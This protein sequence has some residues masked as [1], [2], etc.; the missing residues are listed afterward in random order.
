MSAELKYH[1]FVVLKF[2]CDDPVM[3]SCRDVVLNEF[4]VTLPDSRE[5]NCLG[6]RSLWLTV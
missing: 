1:F 4:V 6:F 2:S 3:W 5:D